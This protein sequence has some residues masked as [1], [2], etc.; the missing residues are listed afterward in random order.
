MRHVYEQQN[1]AYLRT[2]VV[3]EGQYCERLAA[4]DSGILA[5]SWF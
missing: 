4:K 1:T 2:A 5:P 3:K